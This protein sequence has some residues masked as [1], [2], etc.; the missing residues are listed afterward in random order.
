VRP[1]GSF[2]LKFCNCDSD[3]TIDWLN[4]DTNQLCGCAAAQ[5]ADC[6]NSVL[7]PSWWNSAGISSKQSALPFAGMVVGAAAV[8]AGI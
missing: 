4:T 6:C 8:A 7:G 3:C 5:A 2:D 1:D